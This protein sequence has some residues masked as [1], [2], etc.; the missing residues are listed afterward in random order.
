MALEIIRGLEVGYGLEKAY[1]LENHLGNGSQI[2]D[3]APGKNYYH[4]DRLG[5][6]CMFMSVDME[7]L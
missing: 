4:G 1:D 2:K 3:Y 6:A 7:R 5:I